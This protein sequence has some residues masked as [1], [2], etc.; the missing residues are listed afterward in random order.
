MYV[1]VCVQRQ[2][3]MYTTTVLYSLVYKAKKQAKKSLISDYIPHLSSPSS[4]E[5]GLWVFV[6]DK[7]LSPK[8]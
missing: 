1:C 6:S 3:L 2:L 5:G 8:L 4:W 7:Y